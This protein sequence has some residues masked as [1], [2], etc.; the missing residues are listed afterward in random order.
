MSVN[1][2]N[3]NGCHVAVPP[4]FRTSLGAAF[5]VAN[6]SV[7]LAL[8]HCPHCHTVQYPPRAVCRHCLGDGLVWQE[9]GT[10]GRLLSRLDLHHSLAEYFKQRIETSPWPVASVRLDC[11]VV[12]FAHLALAT[13]GV[14]NG[15]NSVDHAVAIP[16]DSRVNVFSHLDNSKNAVL[17][18]VDKQ[19]PI[20]T[21]A[22]RSAIAEAMGL[23]GPAR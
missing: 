20:E 6:A 18:A 19:T 10:S 12:V 13:F 3:Q 11:D 1:P 9:V 7:A 22:Q 4:A 5:T 15:G 21:P 2:E 14:T 16:G 17:I 8:Q 23:F